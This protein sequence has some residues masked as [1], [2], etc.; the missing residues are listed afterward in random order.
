MTR[1]TNFELWCADVLNGVGLVL[2][3]AV[4]GIALWMGAK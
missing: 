4:I 3:A 2:V 1:S